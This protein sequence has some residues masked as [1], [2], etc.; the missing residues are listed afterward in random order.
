MS[1]ININKIKPVKIICAPKDLIYWS[2]IGF[3]CVRREEESA[4]YNE[5][6]YYL[7]YIIQQHEFMGSVTTTYNPYFLFNTRGY[8]EPW[9]L[10][11]RD[12]RMLKVKNDFVGVANSGRKIN[13]LNKRFFIGNK[14]STAAFSKCDDEIW[15]WFKHSQFYPKEG[16]IE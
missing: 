14:E 16:V 7:G 4:M 8:Y 6:G 10:C 1:E 5:I 2:A 9:F 13:I 12:E 11:L 3:S 15:E